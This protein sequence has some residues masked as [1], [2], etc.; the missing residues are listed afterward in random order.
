MDVRNPLQSALKD[1]RPYALQKALKSLGQEDSALGLFDASLIATVQPDVVMVNAAMRGYGAKLG[2]SVRIF[3]AMSQWTVQPDV[4]TYSAAISSCGQW[5]MA[6]KLF[7]TLPEAKIPPDLVSFSSVMTSLQKSVCWQ[8]AFKLFEVIR[9]SQ[10][11]TDAD[12]AVSVKGRVGLALDF[13]L[14]KTPAP[15][16]LDTKKNLS[17]EYRANI[18]DYQNMLINQVRLSNDLDP[19][20]WE[21]NGF[22][23]HVQYVPYIGTDLLRPGE[24]MER[25]MQARKWAGWWVAGWKMG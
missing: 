4:F 20:R 5:Q 21:G 8:R 22:A 10:S 23:G 9:E 7:H 15:A 19:R 13:D 18:R 24:K 25:D 1:N 2:T 17:R 16:Y 12:V 14:T 11:D 6:L 3:E